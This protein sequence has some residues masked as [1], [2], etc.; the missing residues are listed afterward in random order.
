MVPMYN[1]QVLF[2]IAKPIVSCHNIRVQLGHNHDS[3]SDASPIN[4]YNPLNQ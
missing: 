4:A 2:C 3:S 1:A